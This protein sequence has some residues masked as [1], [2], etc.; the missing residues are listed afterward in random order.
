MTGIIKSRAEILEEFPSD[1]TVVDIE[2]TG[3]SPHKCCIIELSALKVRSDSVV[4]KFTSLVKPDGVIN[5]FITGLTGITNDMVAAAPDIKSILPGFME[6]ISDDC[7]L[8][9][10]VSF[11]I[12]FISAN[13]KKYFAS[14][15]TNA[16]KDTMY[17]SR[18]YCTLPCHKL[19]Y[20]A[21]HYN[22]CTG[23]HHRALNDCMM[24]L[25][26]YKNIKKDVTSS[27]NS[28]L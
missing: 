23:G 25:E 1:Y 14:E 4:D 12:R 15:F 7:I 10:N 24:T 16:R 27:L 19:D 8:G 21:R 17:L 9:H 26:V 28:L 11:D 3:L 18:R 20:L 22:I 2:T 5:S 6:F 13:L